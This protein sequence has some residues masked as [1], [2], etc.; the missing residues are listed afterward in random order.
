MLRMGHRSLLVVGSLMAPFYSSTTQQTSR[1]PGLFNRIHRSAWRNRLINRLGTH[2]RP[3]SIA[4]KV[5][6]GGFWHRL[7]LPRGSTVSLFWN[8]QTVSGRVILRSSPRNVLEHHP[9]G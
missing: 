7:G 1:D 8:H 6:K 4:R 9:F 2:E 3:R 5:P